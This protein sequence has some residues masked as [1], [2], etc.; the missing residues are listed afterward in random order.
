[1]SHCRVSSSVLGSSV[2]IAGGFW[3]SCHKAA[4]GGGAELTM[5]FGVKVD[6]PWCSI[7]GTVSL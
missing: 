7:L 3:Q 6:I 2:C 4:A 1:M 5:N